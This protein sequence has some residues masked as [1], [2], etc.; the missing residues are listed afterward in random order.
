MINLKFYDR[1]LDRKADKN[2]KMY[3]ILVD[4]LLKSVSMS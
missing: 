1:E 2:F 3:S 4:T